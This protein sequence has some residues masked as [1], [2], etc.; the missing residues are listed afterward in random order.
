MPNWE[1]SGYCR[2]LDGFPV[3]WARATTGHFT[4]ASEQAGKTR[5]GI[6]WDENS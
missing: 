2:I 4:R 3:M 1:G 5:K 6:E